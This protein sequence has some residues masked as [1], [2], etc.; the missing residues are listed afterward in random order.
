MNSEK[1]LNVSSVSETRTCQSIHLSW[2]SVRNPLFLSVMASLSL[3]SL[4]RKGVE[5]EEVIGQSGFMWREPI[6]SP[7]DH[8]ILVRE[9]K[10]GKLKPHFS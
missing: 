2:I 9:T 6:A 3:N 5:R 8:G 4:S 7:R 1:H 10:G